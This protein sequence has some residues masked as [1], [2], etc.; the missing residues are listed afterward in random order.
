MTT[1]AAQGYINSFSPH[2][3][4][5]G[6]ASESQGVTLARKHER[7]Q[8]QGRR[9]NTATLV[10]CYT[11]AQESFVTLKD[12]CRTESQARVQA[13]EAGEN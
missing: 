8:V 12:R 3:G 9:R 5:L 2:V 10:I 11:G 4:W 1:H 6:S 7:A 13:D